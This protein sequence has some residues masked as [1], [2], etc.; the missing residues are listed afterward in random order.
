M[1]TILKAHQLEKR[2]GTIACYMKSFNSLVGVIATIFL[3]LLFPSTVPNFS[4]RIKQRL[5]YHKYL[6][7]INRCILL[8]VFTALQKITTNKKT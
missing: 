1:K 5:R 4:H 6:Y 7:L 3:P 8:L 2:R